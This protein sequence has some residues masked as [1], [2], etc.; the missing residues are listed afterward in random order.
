MAA[1]KILGEDSEF[2]GRG[3][4]SLH[5]RSNQYRPL[6]DMYVATLF[7]HARPPYSAMLTGRAITWA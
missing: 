6:W 4:S 2:V 3:I 5:I 7:L 1:S